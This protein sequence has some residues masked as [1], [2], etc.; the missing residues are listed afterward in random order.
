LGEPL[1]R[2]PAP[3]GFPDNNAAWLDGIG[4]WLDTANAFSQRNADRLDPAAVLDTTLG[5]LASAETR[6]AIARAES[7]AQAI[8]LLQMAP[9]FLRR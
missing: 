3:R 7:K 9:E 2:P 1:W 4:H 6:Q 5:P 8:T